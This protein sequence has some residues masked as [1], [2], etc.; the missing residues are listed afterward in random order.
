MATSKDLIRIVIA[1]DPAVSSS[2]GADETGIIAAGVGW[3]DCLGE[4]EKHGFILGDY[5]GKYTPDGWASKV[6]W[7]YHHHNADRVVAEDNQGG[8]MVAYTV[9]T[10]D[11]NISYKGVHATHGKYV[12]AEPVAALYEQK[13]IH[14]VGVFRELEDQLCT[15]VQGDK[16]PDRLDALV[17]AI[18]ELMPAKRMISVA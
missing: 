14:H 12:R 10:V 9:R 16:S 11:K 8:E 18:V 17:H 6:A 7:A 3:C 13:K 15:W 4:R 5:S 1:V 2:E